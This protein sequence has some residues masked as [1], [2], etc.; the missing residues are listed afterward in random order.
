MAKGDK[1]KVEKQLITQTER[2]QPGLENIQKETGQRTQAFQD[3]YGPQTQRQLGD[4]GNIMGGYQGFRETLP[5]GNEYLSNFLKGGISGEGGGSLAPATSA[6]SSLS[7]SGGFSPGDIASIRARAI[8]PVH[9]IGDMLRRNIQRTA[10]VR[11]TGGSPNTAAALAKSARDTAYA[12]GDT[13]VNAEAEIAKLTQAGKMAG[14]Q[15]LASTLLGGRGQDLSAINAATGLD[16]D[17]L[18][19]MTGLYGTTP[20]L[21]QLFG[22]QAL[23]SSG[24][25]LQGQD[26]SNQLM[27]MIMSGQINAANIPSTAQNVLSNIGKGVN[28]AKDVGG[29]FTGMG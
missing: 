2:V 3:L 1:K 23:A 9:G 22:Q 10:A 11:G 28:I 18:K 29:I 14:A 17:A 15:G 13:G 26:L 21:S 4:Y 16:L 5:K 6:F 19:G 27:Q 25:Q 12:A 7:S 8:A 24:Q 20:A